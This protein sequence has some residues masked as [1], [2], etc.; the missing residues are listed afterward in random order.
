MNLFARSSLESLDGLDDVELRHAIAAFPSDCRALGHEERIARAH[1]QH[2][3]IWGCESHAARDE[4]HELVLAVRAN[5]PVVRGRVPR[6]GAVLRSV[7]RED[8][9]AAAIRR[10]P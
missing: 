4:M 10:R 8:V 3:A 6:A 2:A 1:R 9:V 7:V 5:D